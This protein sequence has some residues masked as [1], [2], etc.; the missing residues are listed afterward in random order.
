MP[1]KHIPNKYNTN[2]CSFQNIHI[3]DNL[4]NIYSLLDIQWLKVRRV[5]F[6]YLFALFCFFDVMSY[7]AIFP[8]IDE[9]CN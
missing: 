9:F 4:Y 1:N 8:L 2:K 5:S 6:F 7:S 3:I